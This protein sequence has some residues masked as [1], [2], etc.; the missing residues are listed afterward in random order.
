MDLIIIFSPILLI[1]IMLVWLLT[2]FLWKI[3]T[4]TRFMQGKENNRYSL[5]DQC[6][7]PYSP[8]MLVRSLCSPSDCKNFFKDGKNIIFRVIKYGIWALNNRLCLLPPFL[9]FVYSGMLYTSKCLLELS[10]TPIWSAPQMSLKQVKVFS[11]ESKDLKTFL[12]NYTE[13][14]WAKFI[15]KPLKQSNI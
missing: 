14:W 7:R 11:S 12:M 9:K 13:V 10:F 8:L 4:K 15:W 1:E 2:L 5:V 6:F 3:T